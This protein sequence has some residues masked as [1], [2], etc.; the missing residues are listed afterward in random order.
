MTLGIMQPYFLPY[1]G[2]WQLMASVDQFVVYDNIEYTKKG[3]INRNRIL[4]NDTASYVTIPLKKG[5]DFLH[6]ADRSVADDFD[7]RRMVD[8]VVTAY[9]RAP[10][11]STVLPLIESVLLAQ[12][13]NLF[14]YLL[15]SLQVIATFLEI[16]TP[17]V[18]SSTVPIN[19]TLRAEQR[20]LAICHALGAIRYRNAIGGQALY[21][22]T[23][24]GAEGVHL[25][26]IRSRTI[27]Y[28]QF[29]GAFEANLSILDVMM[30][31]SKGSVQAMLGA[32]DIV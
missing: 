14:A 32:F 22:P 29:G 13:T 4:Q 27:E 21:S 25:E 10:Q 3:W 20:V 6:I 17:I 15:N 12:T 19:K 2:Y 16:Q 5:S 11:F 31:N 8:R 24:F 1:I 23:T 26:F 28:A 30:F 18:V 9:R 7:R